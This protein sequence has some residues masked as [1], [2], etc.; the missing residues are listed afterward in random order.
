MD[1]VADESTAKGGT[2]DIVF[3]LPLNSCGMSR[4]KIVPDPRLYGGVSLKSCVSP[5]VCPELTSGRCTVCCD[6]VIREAGIE[7]S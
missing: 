7:R 5:A 2:P 4:S 3:V 1:P 6:P